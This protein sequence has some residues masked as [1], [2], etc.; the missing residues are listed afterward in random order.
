MKHSP[1]KPLSTWMPALKRSRKPLSAG[2]PAL[3]HSKAKIPLPS[4]ARVWH[5]RTGPIPASG[6]VPLFF[7][8]RNQ[9][10]LAK[11][12]QKPPHNIAK[13]SIGSTFD[14]EQDQGTVWPSSWGRCGCANLGRENCLDFGKDPELTF[15]KDD[16]TLSRQSPFLALTRARGALAT[17]R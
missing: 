5:S 16:G 15:R 3:K 13:A 4:C 14:S 7:Q 17:R 10:N 2:V 1:Q 6:M 9:Q 8:L 12:R 11:P